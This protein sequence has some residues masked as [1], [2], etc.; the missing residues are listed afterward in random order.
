M[1]DALPFHEADDNSFNVAFDDYYLQNPVQLQPVDLQNNQDPF[2][3]NLVDQENQQVYENLNNVPLPNLPLPEE[4]SRHAHMTNAQVD[5]IAGNSVKDKTKRQTAWGVAVFR[6]K[7]FKQNI[8]YKAR[9]TF[10]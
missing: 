6:G 10:K 2:L 8:K 7:H 5:F 1:M 3:L 4:A 9:N